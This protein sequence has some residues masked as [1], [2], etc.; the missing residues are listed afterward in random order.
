[1]AGLAV[2]NTE[3]T[4]AYQ[5]L[6]ELIHQAIV[7]TQTSTGEKDLIA[8]SA[9]TSEYR[10][11]AGRLEAKNREVLNTS[12]AQSISLTRRTFS[13]VRILAGLMALVL[14]V[15]FFFIYHDIVTRKKYSDQ[16]KKFNEELEKQVHEKAARIQESEEKYR[17]LFESMT[18]AFVK[19]D[20]KGNFIEFNPAYRNMLGYTDKELFKLSYLDVTPTKW[21]DFEINNAIAETLKTGYSDVYEK[22]Y[23]HK[24]GRIFPVELRTFLLKDRAGQ[25][26]A[27]WAIVRDISRRKEAE[28]KLADSEKNLRHVLSSTSDN[29]YVI[30]KECRVTLINKAA[31][32]NLERAWGKPVHPGSNILELIPSESDEP[33]RE[34]IEKVFAGE[35]VEYELFHVQDDLPPWVLVSYMPV[36]DDAGT[37]TGA[38]IVAKNITERKK[39]ELELR[40]AE[41]KFRN[42]VEQS[43]IG[44]YINMNGRL[45]YVNP[46]F[47]EIFGYTQYEL[48]GAETLSVV[49]PG[50]RERSRHIVQQLTSG[51]KASINFEA[52]GIKKNGDIVPTEVFCTHTLYEGNL[53]I[54]GTLQDISERKEAERAIVENEERYRALVENA[55]EALV[56]L[57]LEKREFVSV[58]ESAVKLFRYSKE[59]LLKMGPVELSPKHQPDG[60]LSSARAIEYLEEA[61]QGKKLVFEWTHCDKYGNAIPCEVWLVRLPAE[62][63]ILIRGSIIDISERKKAEREKERVLHLLNERVK[64]LTTLYRI[65]R[66]FQTEQKP[67][68]EILQE[69]VSMLPSGWQYAEVAAARIQAE[70]L[71]VQSNNFQEGVHKQTATF[72][73]PNDGLGVIEVVYLE[74]KPK[75]TEEAFTAEERNLLNMVA[76]MI[77]IYLARK[78]EAEALKRSE[79]EVVDQKVQAQKRIARAI[80][81]AE[82]KE[83][84][85]IGQE[86]HDNINQIMVSIKLFLSLAKDTG[87]KDLVANAMRL[88]DTAIEEI[89]S[90]SK[91]QVTPGK[92]VELNDLIQS[93]IEKLDD[94]TSINTRFE[95]SVDGQEIADDLKLNIYRIVQEQVNN[96]LK[97]ADAS[98]ISIDIK[99]EDNNLFIEIADDGKG[100]DPGTKRKGIGI[101]NMMNR[102]ESFNGEFT[103]NSEPGKGTKI[104][105]RIPC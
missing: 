11:I 69:I 80:L 73:I 10:D 23:R 32:T 60:S 18:D 28:Q 53:A 102:V 26:T 37:V 92:E 40:D 42:L 46:R 43:L 38:Y 91:S 70:D 88:V 55:P 54:I 71:V 105:I 96:I 72:P 3:E 68:E 29:F 64:E 104:T 77:R 95:Y 56:V 101:S 59:D 2:L 75:E 49:Y 94:S 33:I 103:I 20:M 15:S 35:K 62:N 36:T 34:S 44:V 57:D 13:F 98:N 27:I 66:I 99:P 22:E 67:V 65:S 21:H 50:D 48:I 74:K 6:A 41:A 79:Q 100:F 82:E 84:N 86:L 17:S 47:A 61:R 4:Q 16:L 19:V 14:I 81:D 1:M 5:R 85:K 7:F 8:E 58:S 45:M 87:G 90:L 89:R 83:K 24:S 9:I 76:E 51:Q 30:D 63:R 52:Y 25:P 39:A 31:E 93:L 12:Y 78:H 97:H